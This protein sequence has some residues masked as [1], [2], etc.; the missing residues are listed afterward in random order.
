M[1]GSIF[2]AME[3]HGYENIFFCSEKELGLRAIIVI[4]DT[5]LGPAAGGVRMK[6]YESEAQALEDA[7]RLARSMTYK[8][9]AAGLKY[10]GG[11]CVVMGDPRREKT[12][13][14]FQ[15]LGRFIDRLG[16]L[17][18]TGPDSGTTLHDMEVLR[19][20][21]PYVVTLPESWGGPGDSAPATSFGVVQGMR[22]CLNAVYGSAEVQGRSVAVQGIGAVGKGVVKYLVEGGARVTIADIDE[23]SVRAISSQ[24]AV[25]VVSQ[26]E[27]TRLAVD[28]YCPCAMGGTLSERSIP[29]LRCKIVC[30]SA[31][32]QLAQESDGELL[33]QRGILYAPDY[34]VN[35]GG[36]ICGLDSLNPGG[37]NRE[38]AMEKV[39]RLYDA[40][41]RVIAIARERHIPTYR[42]ADLLAEQRIAQGRLVKRL[43]NYK[44]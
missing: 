30:G 33:H 18:L 15:A 20:E 32:N 13:A 29:E 9:A 36:V 26:Q 44:L 23:E 31:N 19:L 27:I 17:F 6:P 34:I 41:A 11:K 5:T 24:Y 10:G 42:A 14:M 35:A 37:F 40:M 28:V 39:G 7:L 3:A 43:S 25:E 16:G 4:H 1:V 12:E 38:R 2:G 22:A 21:T 8:N